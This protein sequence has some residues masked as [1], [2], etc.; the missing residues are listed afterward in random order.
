MLTNVEA[1]ISVSFL[2]KVMLFMWLFMKACSP[3]LVTESGMTI[4]PMELP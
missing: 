1:L 3:M 4:S 2:G